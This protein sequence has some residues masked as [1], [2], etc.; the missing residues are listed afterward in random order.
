MPSKKRPLDR[1]RSLRFN[2]RD[3][4]QRKQF[5]RFCFLAGGIWVIHTFL[6]SDQSLFAYVDLKTTNRDLTAA[7][8]DTGGR[9]DS[10]A[11]VALL[12]QDDP[13]TIER[14]A[15]ERYKMRAPGETQYLFIEVDEEDRES[16]IREVIRD[17]EE[18]REN[19]GSKPESDPVRRP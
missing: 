11:A 15:R 5:I 13:A 17:R 8:A 4:F 10:L 9:V 7:I 3:Y 6:M 18:A 16:L 14:V 19:A 12:L 2:Y 1:L